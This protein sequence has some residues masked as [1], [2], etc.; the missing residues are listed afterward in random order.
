MS[1]RASADGV[2][3]SAASATGNRT[4]TIRAAERRDAEAIRAIYNAE[5]TSS[6]VTF[7]LVPRTLDDQIAWIDQHS[8]AHPAIVA[9]DEHGA[10]IG[11]ASLSAFKERAAYATSVENSV[12][13]H[14][15]HQ[16]QGVGRRLLTELVEL[17]REHGFHTI[18]A[19]IVGDHATSIALHEACG[20]ELVGVERE[21]GRK[22]S[23]WLDVV[24]MQRM[25]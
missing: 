13:V 6:T 18:I 21:I 23:H 1:S 5:V 19:R 4:I 22:F 10:V 3:P 25:L 14:A 16:R 2:P 9:L 8:G 20:F 7:D 11:F 17:G 12:Y 24:E 15:E